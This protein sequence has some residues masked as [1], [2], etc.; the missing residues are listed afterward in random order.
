[1]NLAFID[2]DKEILSMYDD[3][4]EDLSEKHKLKGKFIESSKS[5]LNYEMMT[6]LVKEADAIFCDLSMP[7]VDGTS[8]LDMFIEVRQTVKRH[9][10]FFIVTGASADMLSFDE[11]GWGKL[12]KADDIFNKPFLFH[13]FTKALKKHGIII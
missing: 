7:E 9:V 4:I 12:V 8:I 2:D 5:I 13:D 11:N 3:F 1:M 10:P 6:K